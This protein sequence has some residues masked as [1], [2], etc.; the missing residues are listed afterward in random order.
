M[1]KQHFYVRG[2]SCKSCE[3]VIERELQKERGIESVCVSHKNRTI[4]IDAVDGHEFTQERLNDL[5][6]KH[7]YFVGKKDKASKQKKKIQWKKV[8]GALILVFGLYLVLDRF[9]IL[10]YSPSSAA[11]AS[12]IGVF[13]VGLV[14]SVSSCTAVV[15]GLV[16]AVAGAVAKEQ[17]RMTRSEKIRPHILFNVGRVAGFF[18]LGMGIGYIGSAVQLSPAGKRHLCYSCRRSYDGHRNQSIEYF[19]ISSDWYAEMARA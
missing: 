17:E 15:G 1:A 7:G 3:V 16:A 6:K 10:R 13:I 19:P 2:T 8:G 18:I 9:G 11:P 14:A 12:L 4:D 5:I